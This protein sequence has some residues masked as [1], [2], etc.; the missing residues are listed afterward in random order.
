ML[1]LARA[2]PDPAHVAFMTAVVAVVVLPVTD[3]RR[4]P[5]SRGLTGDLAEQRIEHRRIRA[6]ARRFDGGEE[7]RDADLRRL[8][9]GLGHRR[10]ITH[11]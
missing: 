7:V 2:E 6:L 10:T 11:D 8:G 9:F 4:A 3:D 1:G 5:H